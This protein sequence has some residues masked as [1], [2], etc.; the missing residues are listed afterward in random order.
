M[1]GCAIK[2]KSVTALFLICLTVLSVRGSMGGTGGG[3]SSIITH[4]S[5]DRLRMRHF[6][7]LHVH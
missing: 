6:G 3:N 5:L 7:T 4:H 2:T 1:Y